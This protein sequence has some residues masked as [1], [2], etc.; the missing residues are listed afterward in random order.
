MIFASLCVCV[1]VYLRTIYIL[2]AAPVWAA[3]CANFEC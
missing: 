1:C 3:T 2:K